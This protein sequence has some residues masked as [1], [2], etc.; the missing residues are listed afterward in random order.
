MQANDNVIQN[1]KSYKLSYLLTA[2]QLVNVVLANLGI[3]FLKSIAV[4]ATQ[5]IELTYGTQVIEG[6]ILFVDNK[7]PT[8][9]PTILNSNTITIRNTSVE[10]IE[11][12]LFLVGTV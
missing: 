8:T 6:T 10:A 5:K 9:L 3:K 11:L 7:L 1:C 4:D 2:G 12:T